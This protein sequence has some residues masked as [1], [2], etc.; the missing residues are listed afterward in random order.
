MLWQKGLGIAEHASIAYYLP[1]RHID[2]LFII[3]LNFSN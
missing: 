1:E 3:T 2:I